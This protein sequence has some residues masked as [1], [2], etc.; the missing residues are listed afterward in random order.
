MVPLSESIGITSTLEQNL[1]NSPNSSPNNLSFAKV[2]FQNNFI[3]M[4]YDVIKHNYNI[5][6]I[7]EMY[8]NILSELH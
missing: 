2:I 5:F 8:K 1:G 6:S 4:M 3:I 7:L